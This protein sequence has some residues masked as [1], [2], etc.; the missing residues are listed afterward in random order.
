MSIFMSSS[1]NRRQK[2]EFE[3]E[4]EIEV[5]TVIEIEAIVI[6]T[7][8]YHIDEKNDYIKERIKSWS[9]NNFKNENL[10]EQFRHD[11]ADWNETRFRFTTFE[12]QRELRAYF[13]LHDVW[14]KRERE[15]V[16]TKTFANTMKKE[17]QTSWIEE[18]IK[19]NIESFDFDVI[20]HFRKTNF[21]RKSRDY[22]W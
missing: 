17:T 11:F 10:W 5:I 13:R 15:I 20:N 22:S 1:I 2:N 16:I 12:A 18:K 19:N 9:R 8:K 4:L 21:E 14:I 6:K 7:R 3:S